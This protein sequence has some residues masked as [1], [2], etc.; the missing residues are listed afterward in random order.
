MNRF[1][2]QSFLNVTGRLGD[3]G[4]EITVRFNT[5][6]VE[7][8]EER[9]DGTVRIRMQS[10]FCFDVPGLSLDSVLEAMGY[11][12]QQPVANDKTTKKSG[13]AE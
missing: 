2:L 12:R 13:D 5:S 3:S 4:E 10:G 9:A 8:F 7:V 1:G 6:M 11:A